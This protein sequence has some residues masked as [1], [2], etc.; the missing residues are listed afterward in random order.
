MAEFEFTNE[1]LEFNR[2]GSLSPRQKEW[3]EK[4]AVTF[5]LYSR[6]GMWF[7]LAIVPILVCVI[8]SILLRN[9]SMRNSLASAGPVVWVV[10]G[11]GFFLIFGS[12]IV[13]A[14]VSRKRVKNFSQA[15][16]LVAEGRASLHTTYNPRF[17]RSHYIML[18]DK[19]LDIRWEG[20]F[21]EGKH[22]RVYY[23]KPPGFVYLMSLEKLS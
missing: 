1:D 7:N 13:G 22:Y 5:S 11:F 16:L 21:D 10:I 3:M 2:Q 23:C 4:Q 20:K 15:D 12:V 18:D 17:G 14:F 19:R 6:A 8:G 9:E